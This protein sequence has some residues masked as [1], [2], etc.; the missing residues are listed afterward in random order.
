MPCAAHLR[1][2]EED[3]AKMVA[4]RKHLGLMRQIGAAA[5]DQ[6]D[7]RQPVFLRDLLRAEMLL[8]RHRIIGA[9]LH[10]GVVAHDH[11]LAARDAAD[12][13]NHAGTRNVVLA[14]QP[15]GGKLA[16]LE[17]RRARI[18]QPFHPVT[19]EQ[20]A[21]IDM[22]L[23]TAL[24]PAQRS[25]RHIGAQIFHQRTI[26]RGIGGKSLTAGVDLA[27]QHRRTHGAGTCVGAGCILVAGMVSPVTATGLASSGVHG[28]PVRQFLG[29]H[30]P[31][32]I[33]RSHLPHGPPGITGHEISGA[34]RTSRKCRFF[35]I[36]LLSP[37]AARIRVWSETVR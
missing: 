28:K 25:G 17:E 21:P 37:I 2:V 22:T 23:P 31:R 24:G 33:A 19:R 26:M 36:F 10:R 18:E 29:A 9:A 35:A 32:A 15:V 34:I 16:D 30:R 1:L 8:H 12:A 27:G 14:V 13:C 3:A 6:I 20:L 4:V 11:A 5:I 7:A